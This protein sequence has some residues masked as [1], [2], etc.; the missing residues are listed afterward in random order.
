MAHAWPE[1]YIDGFGWMAFEPTPGYLGSSG[2]G[3]EMSGNGD[4]VL[5]AAVM[6]EIPDTA[7]NDLQTLHIRKEQKRFNP[8][9]PAVIAMIAVF[10]L[11]LL[12]ASERF[13]LRR[14]FRAMSIEQKFVFR[15]E[16][17]KK[18]FDQL[19]FSRGSSET[20]CEF[21]DRCSRFFG[22]AQTEYM[23][24]YA[25]KIFGNHEI[26]PE[27]Y[28]GAVFSEKSILEEADRK[29]IKRLLLIRIWLF[30]TDP[31]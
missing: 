23:N 29:G 10:M 17:N 22:E 27:D 15:Y 24:C 28:A 8:V 14:R 11:L 20:L 21:H 26:L 7:G 30:V 12:F 16:R 3:W 5:Q 25:G 9:I 4:T 31:G 18:L 13:I 6:P 2:A 1:A 19:G